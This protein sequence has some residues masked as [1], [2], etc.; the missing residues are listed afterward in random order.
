MLASKAEKA[1]TQAHEYRAEV[2]KAIGQLDWVEEGLHGLQNRD[3]F[4][5][6]PF[7][8]ACRAHGLRTA[9]PQLFQR[10]SRAC[11]QPCAMTKARPLPMLAAHA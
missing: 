3:G 2:D 1:L 8:S 5:I 11:P 4:H 7:F 10:F 9:F 6:R